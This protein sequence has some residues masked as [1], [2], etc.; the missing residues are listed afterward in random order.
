MKKEDKLLNLK[1]RLFLL[2]GF[3]YKGLVVSFEDDVICIEKED[4]VFFIPFH[5]V[6]TWEVLD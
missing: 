1:V 2:G 3:Q 5:A 6:S 4:G